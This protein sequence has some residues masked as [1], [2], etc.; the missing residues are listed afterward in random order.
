MSKQS[1]AKEAQGFMKKPHTCGD[2]KRFTCDEKMTDYG[3][4]YG[5]YTSQHNLRCSKGGF[6]VGKSNTCAQWEG[7]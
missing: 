7:K 1:D 2:C 5:N 6:K 4:G 3:P